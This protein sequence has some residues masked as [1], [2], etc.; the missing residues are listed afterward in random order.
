MKALLSLLVSLIIFTQIVNAQNGGV[1]ISAT[2]SSPDPSAMLDVQSTEK[3]MLVPRMTS[4]QRLA[5]VNPASS[6]LVYDTDTETFWFNQGTSLAPLWSEIKMNNGVWSTDGSNIFTSNSTNNV[7]IGTNNP[8][9]KLVIQA[10]A[11]ALDTDTLLVVKNKSGKA[12]FAIFNNNVEVY[13]DSKN[14]SQNKGFTVKESDVL[15]KQPIFT[16]T[17]DS[18]VFYLAE[19]AKGK[20]KGL[21]VRRMGSSTKG[22]S[23]NSLF[24]INPLNTTFYL[25]DDTK[26]KGLT[27]KRV[28]S[29]T[30]GSELDLFN[31]SADS[32]TISTTNQDKRV[33]VKNPDLNVPLLNV[34]GGVK[35]ANSTDNS[36]GVIKY[37]GENFEGNV[38]AGQGAFLMSFGSPIVAPTVVDITTPISVTLSADVTGD[39]GGYVFA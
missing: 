14:L 26:S 38:T 6:L 21:V 15:T 1:S 23:T 20:S 24:E 32:T 5:I 22:I 29:T 9:S 18:T 39:G 27:V 33:V 12:V 4:A 35:V 10:D 25:A 28:G 30:K 13:I 8:Q 34:D 11:N 31:I 3:G 36:E 17:P 19:T 16:V 7:G 37:T 2:N